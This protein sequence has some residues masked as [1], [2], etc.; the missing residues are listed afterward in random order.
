MSNPY[1]LGKVIK[2]K[3]QNAKSK[4]KESFKSKVNFQENS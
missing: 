3:Q 4:I 2:A 1:P